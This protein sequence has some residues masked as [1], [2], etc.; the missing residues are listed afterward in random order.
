MYRPKTECHVT[1]RMGVV[2]YLNFNLLNLYHSTMR[3]AY[4]SKRT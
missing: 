1:L 2:V 4:T 3:G